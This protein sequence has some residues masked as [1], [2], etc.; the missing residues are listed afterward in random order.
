MKSK[1]FV[2]FLLLIFTSTLL[3]CKRPKVKYDQTKEARGLWVTRWEW[4]KPELQNNPEEQQ[5]RIIEIFEN[6]KQ[7]KLNFILFQV[8]G[9]G[10]AFY[11]SNFEPWSDLLTGTLGQD[12][13][14]DPLQ[15]AVEQAHQRGLELHAWV[16]TFPAWRGTEPPPHTTPEHVYHAHPE[17][18]ICDKNGDPM[19]L[20]GHYV[21]LSPGIPEVQE[22]VHDVCLEIIKNYDIDGLHFDYIR[23]P[24]GSPDLGYSH[25]PISLRLFNSAEGNPKNLSWEDWQ[26]EN[27]NQ[28]V[29]KFYDDANRIK[30]WIKISAAVIGK[31]NYSKWN[32]YHVVYQDALQWVKEGK[33]DFICPMIYWPSSHPTAPFGNIVQQWLKNY[34]HS[35]Y[36]FPGMMINKLG[37][38]DWPL[39]EVAR[40]VSIVRRA[41]GNGMV[42]FSYS[43]L[44]KANDLLKNNGFQFLANFPSMPWKEGRPPMEPQ[45]L[46]A[47]ISGNRTVILTWDTLDSA[48]QT[49][50]VWK[51]NIF[52]SEKSP[53]NIFEAENLIHIARAEETAYI[54][55]VPDPSKTYYYVIA[56]L[57]RL[58][59]E[60]P[61]SNEIMV[62]F[63]RVA[64]ISQENRTESSL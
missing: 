44:E 51:Y 28:F 27:I 49:S 57:D 60:S 30:P 11:K 25:D 64:A 13:G 3:F 5:A 7:A 10:D 9:N 35:R 22:Y 2:I 63:P 1:Y 52:R 55:A 42:F 8:R 34:L 29:R 32:G 31:Y 47:E 21:N 54:D 48:F 45:N 39:E 4:A 36:I 43:G 46:R 12:P 62:T 40:Q 6:A 19:P 53:V 15:F 26:R 37:S 24:E 16:N 59:N 20:S 14:W 23:Y 58:N 33:I 38:E 41:E 18:I 56:A 50:K 17:W 61:P